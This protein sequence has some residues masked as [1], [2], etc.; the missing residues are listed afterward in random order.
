MSSHRHCIRVRLDA[1]ITLFIHFRLFYRYRYGF[2]SDSFH[3]HVEGQCEISF[4]IDLR[5]H[6]EQSSA[7]IDE[8]NTL[9]GLWCIDTRNSIWC[10]WFWSLSG[11]SGPDDTDVIVGTE[12]SYA[13]T[14]PSY[15]WIAAM[16]SITH[17]GTSRHICVCV[18]AGDPTNEMWNENVPVVWVTGC[19]C[20]AKTKE[21]ETPDKLRML[22][23]PLT[24]LFQRIF[25]FS[26]CPEHAWIGRTHVFIWL[27]YHAAT[28]RHNFILFFFY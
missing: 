10:F 18:C 7:S 5:H 15:D 8:R 22:Q 23:R 13:C 27:E 2:H 21:C 11:V 24:K 26:S 20:R 14:L 25:I 28:A 19:E 17:F 3:V 16:H 1:R 4:C 9:F 12:I 6:I